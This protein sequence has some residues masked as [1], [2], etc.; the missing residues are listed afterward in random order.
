MSLEI[1]KAPFLFLENHP[2]NYTNIVKNK[3]YDNHEDIDLL[4]LAFFSDQNMD[5]IQKQTIL[6]IF[7]EVGWKVPYQRKTSITIVMKYIYNFYARN[8]PYKIT[9][10]IRDLNSKVVAEIVPRMITQIEQYLG[11][12]RDSN[13]PLQCLERPINPTIKGNNNF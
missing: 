8:L 5:I 1:E 10:Q 11:Y 9:E 4:E 12:I 2:N 3:L 13:R 7:R 6:T